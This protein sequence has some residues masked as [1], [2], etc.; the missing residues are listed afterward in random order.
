MKG[1]ATKMT[2]FM[3]GADK[4]FVI[5]VYQRKYDWKNDNCSQLM[6]EIVTFLAALCPPSCP[7]AAKSNITLLTGSNALPPFHYYFWLFAIRLPAAR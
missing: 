7:T 6:E 3:E 1:S 5:P 4:R 2:G